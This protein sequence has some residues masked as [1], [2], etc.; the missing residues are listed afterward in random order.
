MHLAKALIKA[1]DKA[2]ARKELETLA[3]ASS[4]APSNLA[5]DNKGAGAAQKA[6]PTSIARTPP[7]S[8]VAEC[9]AEVAELLKTL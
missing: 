8:C 9:A 1:G 6:S 4:T 7:L 3:Q 5:P 2:G